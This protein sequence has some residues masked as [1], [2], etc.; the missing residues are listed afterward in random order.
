MAVPVN[1]IHDFEMVFLTTLE[2]RY[3]EILENFK[4]GKLE[5]EDTDRMRALASELAKQYKK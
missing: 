5:K 2:Q 3:P 1:H 4:A